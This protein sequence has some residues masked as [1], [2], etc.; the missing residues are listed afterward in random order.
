MKNNDSPNEEP[1]SAD[2]LTDSLLKNYA[3]NP[4]GADDEAFLAQ[5]E[6]AMD[7]GTATRNSPP[8]KSP[9]FPNPENSNTG[10][11]D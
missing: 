3:A 11:G 8:Q 9:S 7:T 1:A 10:A 6:A 4:D 2:L 5:V